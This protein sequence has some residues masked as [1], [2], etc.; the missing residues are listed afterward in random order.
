[1]YDVFVLAGMVLCV[2]VCLTSITTS[3]DPHE[4]LLSN[5]SIK[6]GTISP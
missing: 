2:D 4:I 6:T 5:S 3:Y 1:M